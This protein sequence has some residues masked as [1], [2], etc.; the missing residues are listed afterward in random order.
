MSTPSQ[1]PSAEPGAV[2][3]T[4]NGTPEADATIRQD[5]AAQTEGEAQ[6]ARIEAE[7]RAEEIH[8]EVAHTEARR[9]EE[10]TAKAT[11]AVEQAERRRGEAEREQ[12]AAHERDQA[13]RTDAEQARRQADESGAA[14][15]RIGPATRFSGL[16]E[17]GGEPIVFGP[18]TAER[19]ELL[20]IA[21]L[22][23][24]FVLAKIVRRMAD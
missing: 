10:Q 16:P 17:A 13:A 2:R 6:V 1:D 23:A 3:V 14:G 7:A 20:V 15:R 5:V 21:A 19:P 11:E 4:S 9:A 24:G 12:A 18:F 8:A 22:A